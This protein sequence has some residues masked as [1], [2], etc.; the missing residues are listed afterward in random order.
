[1]THEPLKF[2]GTWRDRRGRP[3]GW[4]LDFAELEGVFRPVGVR[5]EAIG[6]EPVPVTQTHLRDFPLAEMVRRALTP[7][8][9]LFDTAQPFRST[10]ELDDPEY[11]TPNKEVRRLNARA[12]RER[13]KGL[14]VERR[15]QLRDRARKL[16]RSL[17]RHAGGSPSPGIKHY[18]QVAETYLAARAAGDPP[19]QAVMRKF[20][21]KKSTAA[22][23]VRRARH[24]Y[25]LLGPATDGIPAKDFN[26]EAK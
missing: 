9:E 26:E 18:Q 23:H 6:G 5:L 15:K 1:M 19:L 7:G 14:G 12:L 20:A 11:R 2:R 17:P 13:L 22:T 16:Q 3:W 24:S 8:A 10:R 21:L 25:G 4:E